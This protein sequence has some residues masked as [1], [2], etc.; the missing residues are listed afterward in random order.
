M[1]LIQQTNFS[2]TVSQN[3]ALEKVQSPLQLIGRVS[4][5]S[6][7]GRAF[8][9]EGG[10][11]MVKVNETTF[12]SPF[13]FYASTVA[14]YRFI[15]TTSITETQIRFREA[16]IM[17]RGSNASTIEYG[18]YLISLDATAISNGSGLMTTKLFS[19]T[20]TTSSSGIVLDS[21]DFTSEAQALNQ[22]NGGYLL[23]PYVQNPNGA[24]TLSL[25]NYT[26]Y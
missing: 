25:V 19:E 24:N 5:T 23:F 3:G 16:T 11:F 18:I 22:T 2:N 9:V 7:E 13:P 15:T 20:L 14:R 12:S 4:F 21:Y 10:D 6:T 26:L 17:V 8:F 1:S